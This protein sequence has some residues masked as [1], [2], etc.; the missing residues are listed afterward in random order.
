MAVVV[1]TVIVVGCTGAPGGSLRAILA[2]AHDRGRLAHRVA[3]GSPHYPG[4][5]AQRDTAGEHDRARD[6]LVRPPLVQRRRRR[7]RRDRSRVRLRDPPWGDGFVGVGSVDGAHGSSDAAFFAS[8][9]GRHW[10]VTRHFAEAA[11]QEN[12]GP[13]FLVPLGNELLAVSDNDGFSPPNLWQSAD[14]KTWRAVD[15]PSFR[16]AWTNGNLLA[17]AGGPAGVVAIGSEGLSLMEPGPPIVAT[18]TD[19]S[20]WTRLTLPSAFDHAIFADVLATRAGFVIVGRD[21]TPDAT[22]QRGGARGIGAPAAWVSP[23]GTTWAAA[24]V[25][26]QPVAGGELSAVAAG[27]GGLFA[28]G[29]AEA[30]G[31]LTGWASTDGS[32]WRQTGQLGVD[33]PDPT[34]L[35]GDGTHLVILGR[36]SC[37]TTTLKAWVSTDG[38]TWSRLAF[39]GS[40]VIP[41]A[42]GPIC[43]ADG[44]EDWNTGGMAVATPSSCCGACWSSAPAGSRRSSGSPPHGRDR[45]AAGWKPAKPATA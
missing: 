23:D 6:G 22:P 18:S 27:A 30:S 8:T 37:K 36:S 38:M 25:E 33:L 29:R 10:T 11:T 12:A 39:S 15:S 43:R 41:D 26:G 35:S 13:Q 4:P 3:D 45:R 24:R 1:L 28:V 42:G 17:V 7:L 19:G 32:T 14:G 44:T 20:T 2:R 21:G 40:T 16:T 34:V 5:V 9:D 31:P